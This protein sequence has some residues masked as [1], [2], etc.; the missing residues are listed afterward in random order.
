MPWDKRIDVALYSLGLLECITI[1]RLFKNLGLQ[2][3]KQILYRI[4][5]CYGSQELVSKPFD[6]RGDSRMRGRI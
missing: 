6:R 4:H 2:N 3:C 1:D 5:I